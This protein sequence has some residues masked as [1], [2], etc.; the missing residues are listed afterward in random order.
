MQKP[1]SQLPAFFVFFSIIIL[2]PILAFSQN[3]SIE[4]YEFVYKTI[5]NHEI[6]ANIFLPASSG[7]HPVVVYFHGGGFI[8]GNRDQDLETSLK[9]KLLANNYAVVSADYRLAPETKLDGIL[10]DVGDVVR[11]LK[12]NG[13]KEYSIDVTRIAAMGGSS[14]GYLAYATGFNAETAPNAIVAIS[15]PTGFLA[16]NIQMGDLSILDQPGPYDIVK[17]HPVSY[18][19]YSSRMDLWRFLAANRLALY[20]IFG[21]DP[22]TEPEKLDKFTLTANVKPDYPPTLIVHAKN[23]RL[24]DLGQVTA[25]YDFLKEKKVKSE[26]YLVE[27]GHSTELINQN[28]EAVDKIIRFLNKQL[29]P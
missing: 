11:W 19:D 7:L 9:D 25:F 12:L 13:A 17:D 24:V 6:K 20:E 21:F 18:G 27:Y 15:A 26:I 2:Q 4:K 10:Q 23:D 5:K 29:N 16:A 22:S 14:G 1:K 28:P 8:F 3:E